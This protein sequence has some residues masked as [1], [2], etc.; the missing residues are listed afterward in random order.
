MVL[1]LKIS[2]MVNLNNY[3]ITGLILDL[4]IS[5]DRARQDIK[6]WLLGPR[7]VLN[8]HKIHDFL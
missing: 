2:Y 6:N 7:T 4:I 8:F 3:L 5:L 1:D